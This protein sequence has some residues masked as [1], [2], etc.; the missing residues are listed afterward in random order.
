MP[1]PKGKPRSPETKE[2]LRQAQLKRFAN[3]EERQRLS[4]YGKKRYEDP[5][6]RQ[7][8]SIIASRINK[9]R[10]VSETT[11]TRMSEAQQKVWAD[12][13]YVERQRQV[14]KGKHFQVLSEETK[15]KISAARMGK[16]THLNSPET[17]A[18]ISAA[19]R[20][21]KQP[22]TE[23]TRAAAIQRGL[24]RRGCPAPEVPAASRQRAG[25]LLRQRWADPELRPQ[26]LQR[27]Q[28]VTSTPESWEKRKAKAHQYWQDADNK[29]RQ[30]EWLKNHW[31]DPGMREQW[32]A[33]IKRA[34]ASPELRQRRR[35]MQLRP[36]IAARRA[37][38]VAAAFAGRHPTSIERAV[39]AVLD[40]LG[41]A[42][43]RQ[44]CL[45]HWVVDFY[46]PDKNLVIEAEG[47]YWHSLPEVV[48]KDARRDAWLTAHGYKVLR[49]AEHDIKAD[50]QACVLAGLQTIA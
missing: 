45:G 20:G 12:P 8:Q 37:A 48:E 27:F 43:K 4:E 31:N 40:E 28:S 17:R 14:Q 15:A 44:K 42:Y 49:L 29:A 50:A 19:N 21:R 30:S 36:D 18:K 5:A 34:C 13:A 3:P 1:Y 23:K 47:D 25:E 16:A 32:K 22:V 2:K 24:A 38:A 26:L 35:E 9:G 41:I 11:R 46:I 39:Q 6:E 7:K 10:P 33:S